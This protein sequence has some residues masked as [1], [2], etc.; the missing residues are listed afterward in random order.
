[1]EARL[2]QLRREVGYTR[3][4]VLPFRAISAARCHA[5][6]YEQHRRSPYVF[7]KKMNTDPNLHI[8]VK[9]ETTAFSDLI[10]DRLATPAKRAALVAGLA[11]TKPMEIP[12]PPV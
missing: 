6:F 3:G 8:S 10:R 5:I 1:V 12:D 7:I 11:L 2:D 9:A 4:R